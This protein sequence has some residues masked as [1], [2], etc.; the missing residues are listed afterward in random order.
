MK[1]YAIVLAAGKGTRM[2]SNRPKVVHE[3][4]YKPMI[5]HIVEQLKQL[6]I[7]EIF[8]VVGYQSEQVEAVIDGVTFVHQNEQLG[9]GHAIMQ[10]KELLADK[11]GTTLILNG[12]APL[13]RHETL[14]DL[15]NFHNENKFKGTIM[16]CDCDLDT[17]FGR[18]IKED[19][20]VTGIVEYR[21]AT[22]AQRN[23]PEMNVGEY[24]FDNI[25]LFKALDKIDSNNDQ[26]EYYLTDVVKIMNTSGLS[27]GSYKIP[28]LMEVGGINNLYEL[29]QATKAMQRRVNKE[30]M[31]EGVQIIDPENTYISTDAIIGVHTL[32]EPGCIIKGK[33]KIGENC[34][35]G[36]NCEIVNT[37]IG[38]GVEIKFSVVHDSVIENN[39]DMGPY[40]RLRNNCHILEGV[41][42]GNFVE[43]KNAT[44]GVGSKAAHLSYIG[45]AIVGTN[46]N[47]GCGTITV[48]YDGK[49]K[50]K[51]VIEDN[52]FIGCNANL[53][54]PLVIGQGAFVAAGSTVTKDV[55]PD[56]FAI[57]R[58]KEVIKTGYAK[59]LEEKRNKK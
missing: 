45:D 53:V 14:N 18:I 15:R 39:V 42:M 29:A 58:S 9:T 13:I 22:D 38:N 4:L 52:A 23:I 33:T 40:V 34:R 50:F 20:Q 37:T 32:I 17:R 24:C 21:D 19:N 30:L 3:V 26:N 28:D 10:A 46:V 12:D 7:D 6:S 1:T 43:M 27:V 35:I 16:T 25:E 49:N 48:N 54:A 47:I 44:F 2:K 31:I 8:V 51:T 11:E 55:G 36:P 57:A 59:I 41:H 56:D 5:V